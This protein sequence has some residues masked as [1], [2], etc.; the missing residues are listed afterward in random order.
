MTEGFSVYRH[1]FL[2]RKVVVLLSTT[3]REFICKCS[4]QDYS[5]YEDWVLQKECN[6]FE[7]PRE[8]PSVKATADL[9][10]TQLPALQPVSFQFNR[11]SSLTNLFF[12]NL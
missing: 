6:I 3:Y 1:G 11:H 5:C 7:A 2:K 10:L 4:F 12:F 9:F 8:F